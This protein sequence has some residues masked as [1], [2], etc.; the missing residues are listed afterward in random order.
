MRN[1]DSSR[2]PPGFDCCAL[3]MQ[4][5]VLQHI[6]SESGHSEATPFIGVASQPD[7]RPKWSRVRTKRSRCAL[8]RASMDQGHAVSCTCCLRA[9]ALQWYDSAMR[10]TAEWLASIGLSEFAQRF[11]ENG[12]DLSTVRDLTEQDLKDLGS[13]H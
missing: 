1:V 6:P 9:G 8:S 4:Q 2:R 3:A 11:T 5:R 7:R 12:I 10:G 13:G